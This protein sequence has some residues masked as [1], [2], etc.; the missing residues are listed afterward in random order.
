[1]FYLLSTPNAQRGAWLGW[2]IVTVGILFWLPYALT[3]QGLSALTGQ[4][5]ALIIWT[6]QTV[7][8]VS[9]ANQPG[10]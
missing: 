4:S 6:I 7:L 5:G 9:V 2:M 8:V 1:M 3:T 10:E